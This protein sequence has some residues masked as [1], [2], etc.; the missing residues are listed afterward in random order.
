MTEFIQKFTQIT[1]QPVRV[2][3]EHTLFDKQVFCCDSLEVINDDERI[4]VILKG[5]EIFIYKKD[6]QLFKTLDNIFVISDGR[7]QLTVIVKKV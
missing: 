4:G 6:I 3:M 5:R 1:G 2:L 7:L